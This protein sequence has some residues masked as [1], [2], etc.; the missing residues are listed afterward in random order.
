DWGQ[1]EQVILNLAV[2]ARDA[3]PT[4]G[5]LTIETRNVDL[6]DTDPRRPP[7]LSPGHYVRLAVTD[8]G[9]G[10]DPDTMS[11]IFEP[12]FST[13]ADGRGTG[14]GLATVF[15]IVR[16]SGGEIVVD[17]EPGRGTEFTIH[18]PRTD[19]TIARRERPRRP[20]EQPRGTETILL[21]EDETPVRQAAARILAKYGYT[22]L[23]AQNAGEG[24]M[25]SENHPGP[26]H[27]LLTDVVLPK[28]SGVQFAERLAGIRPETKVLFMSGYTDEA[29]FHHGVPA[30][31][32]NFIAK[33]FTPRSLARK[34]CQVLSAPS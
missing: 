23:E 29:V 2:N 1:M 10:M 14:L 34:V 4:G 31:G 22:V 8:T 6:G 19:A 16:Q 32:V 30:E 15:G 18:L 33:P 11:R 9:V 25:I 27:L 20:D 24:L 12:F 17:S 3:M 21:L 5:A 28:I 26:I 7:G 13:K